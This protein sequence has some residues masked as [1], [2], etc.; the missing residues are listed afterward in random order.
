M[1][2]IP[3]LALSLLLLMAGCDRFEHSFAADAP[4]EVTVEEFFAD[5]SA[6]MALLNDNSLP[7]LMLFYHENYNN[8]GVLKEDVEAFYTQILTDNPNPQFTANLDNY[9]ENLNIEWHLQVTDTN[10]VIIVDTMFTDV[11]LAQNDYFCFYGN[12]IAPPEV[13]KVLIELGTALWCTSCPYAEAALHDL[14]NQYG[15]QLY[16]I[17]YHHSDQLAV[18]G[19][20]DI[21]DYYGVTLLPGGIFQGQ[22]I[23]SSG[24]DTTYDVYY[25]TLQGFLN[26]PAHA[27]LNDFSFEINGQVLNGNIMID[28][29]ETVSQDNL[30]LKYTLVEEVTQYQNYFQEPCLQA[31]IANGQVCVAAN[32]LSLPVYFALNLPADLPADTKFYIWLQTIADIYDPETCRIYN[33]IETD[34]NTGE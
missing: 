16:Y 2:I 12:Q 8:N 7:D 13:Q 21:L 31:A 26:Q 22:T 19:N 18:P 20:V 24:N 1:K 5:F 3:F 28:I 25:E 15:D 30:V 34:I 14:K 33:V 4:P 11:L 23:I 9:D 17:E 10:R 29:D 32:D 27:F 6:A